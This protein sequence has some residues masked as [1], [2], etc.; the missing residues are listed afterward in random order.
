MTS[1]YVKWELVKRYGTRA[2]IFGPGQ[3]AAAE[4]KSSNM[5]GVSGD[6]RL[7]LSTP[8]DKPHGAKN[9]GGKQAMEELCTSR[10]QSAS[11]AGPAHARSHGHCER[12][13]RS[14]ADDCL[15]VLIV[16]ASRLRTTF[17]GPLLGIEKQCSWWCAACG[18]Q[19]EWRSPNRTLVIQ[20]NMNR[21][22]AK[23]SERTLHHKECVTT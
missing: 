3:G 8:V 19:Y 15:C 20:D 12:R 1:F 23:S 22:D 2:Q 16:T 17:G 9:G 6:T 21:R 10:V 11:H 5:G 7:C 13:R 4:T 18:G 14:S